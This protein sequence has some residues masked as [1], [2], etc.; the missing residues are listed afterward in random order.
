M[1]VDCTD[2]SL[3]A[4]YRIPVVT[5]AL[6]GPFLEPVN[7][8]QFPDYTAKVGTRMMDLGTMWNKLTEGDG[9]GYPSLETFR[10]D[11]NLIYENC[12][13][14]CKDRF[15]SLPPVRCVVVLRSIGTEKGVI[16]LFLLLFPQILYFCICLL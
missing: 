13:A 5:N 3:A 4:C 1:A 10:A 9:N 14:Y 16:C 6:S 8:T 2:D 11:M 12:E 15:P 7:L